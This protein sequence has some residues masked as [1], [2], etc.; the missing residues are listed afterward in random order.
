M[1]GHGAEAGDEEEYD[2]VP[3][4][5]VGRFLAFALVLVGWLALLGGLAFAGMAIGGISGSQTMEGTGG[6]PF[7]VVVGIAGF[8]AGLVMVFLGSMARAV[9]EAANNTREL[10]EIERA[11]SGW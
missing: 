9:F 1:D 5:R 8:L 6:L 4:Y 3:G 10:L 7:G 2:F 11:R